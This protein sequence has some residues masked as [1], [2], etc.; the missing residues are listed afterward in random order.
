MLYKVQY[1]PTVAKNI[2]HAF[3]ELHARKIWHGDVR[4]ENILVRSDNTVVV[5]DFEWSEIN[6]QPDK[7]EAEMEEVKTLLV[8]WK[9]SG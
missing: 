5:I 9:L 3:S 1:N 2:L 6:A 8:W 7:L 4:E